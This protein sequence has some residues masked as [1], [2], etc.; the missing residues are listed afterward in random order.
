MSKVL[1]LRDELIAA[2]DI[3]VQ[4][5]CPRAAE[6]LRHLSK[7]IM[8]GKPAPAPRKVKARIVGGSGRDYP[9]DVR[10]AT[11]ADGTKSVFPQANKR[12]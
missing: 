10:I 11:A 6:R 5:D 12:K 8:D 1:T 2:I 9:I 3:L 7:S 4:A